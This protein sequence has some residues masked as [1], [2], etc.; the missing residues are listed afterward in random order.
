MWG[1]GGSFDLWTAPQ[2]YRAEKSNGC[3]SSTAIACML[4]N[5][6]DRHRPSRAHRR[7]KAGLARC[8]CPNAE[9]R[10]P[11]SRQHLGSQPRRL[12]RIASVGF[13]VQPRRSGGNASSS[14][15]RRAWSAAH[16]RHCAQRAGGSRHIW[17]R[18]AILSRGF[19]Q[20]GRCLTRLNILSEIGESGFDRG[21]F[22]L[23][24]SPAPLGWTQINL[25]RFAYNVETDGVTND[26]N[27]RPWDVFRGNTLIRAL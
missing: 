27:S 12:W 21:R 3:G 18:E 26:L 11:R 24:T 25:F 8:A 4:W 5:P 9:H 19:E 22:T 17:S 14:R 23:R 15:N 1:W 20:T 6:A 16:D 2:K 7:R 13:L 10:N